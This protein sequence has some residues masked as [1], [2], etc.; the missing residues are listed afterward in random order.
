M[1]GVSGQ[2][3]VYAGGS[4]LNATDVSGR[5]LD[6]L[7]DIAA[8]GMDV[9]DIADNGLSWENGLMLVADVGLAL[10]PF[11]P[12]V[13]GAALRGGKAL[14]H[15]D[16]AVSVSGLLAHADKARLADIRGV[17]IAGRPSVDELVEITDKY[18]IEF[19]VTYK[20][21]P[22]KNGGGGTYYLHAGEHLTVSFPA[23]ANRM[24]IY[25]THPRGALTSASG[26]DMTAMRA[27]ASRGSP[28]RSSV[29]VPV[30]GAPFRFGIGR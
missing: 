21:G 26:M 4:P 14:A 18:N 25:H 16:D 10:V 24:L 30:E 17:P 3:Y 20:Y 28:Q 5:F 1:E 13:G 9:K 19:A 29:I 2:P 6:T 7:F 22:G 27:L 8:I 12:A 15:A 11:A 23:E